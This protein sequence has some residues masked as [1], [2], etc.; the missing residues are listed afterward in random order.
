MT[1][2]LKKIGIFLLKIMDRERSTE[3][4]LLRRT[5][6]GEPI[7]LGGAEA[8]TEEKAVSPF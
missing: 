8:F 7:F 4:E 6:F 1:G 2:S 3:H 5:A